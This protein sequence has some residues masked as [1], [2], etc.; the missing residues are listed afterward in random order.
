MSNIDRI[1]EHSAGLGDFAQA[2][3]GYLSGVLASAEPEAIE[4]FGEALEAARAREATVFVAGNGGSAATASTMANDLGS[5]VMRKAGTNTPLRVFA[6]TDNVSVLTAVANDIGYE[7]AFVT[8]LRIHYRPGDM[9]VVISASGNSPTVVLAAEWVRERGGTVAGLVG[10]DGGKL[11]NLCD[12]T[13]HFKTDPGEYGPV[14]DAHLVM[15]HLLSHWF[16]HRFRD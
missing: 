4:A 14:E 7:N 8:Q 9:L 2:Y 16:Q 12:I 10:F 3:F 6:L 1:Y 5:D 13:V 11:K 15:N